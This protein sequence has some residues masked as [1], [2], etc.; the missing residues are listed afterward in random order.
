M[1]VTEVRRVLDEV[2]RGQLPAEA[3]EALARNMSPQDLVGALSYISERAG[4]AD[5]AADVTSLTRLT[6]DLLVRFARS[7]SEPWAGQIAGAAAD[8]YRA[9]LED[10]ESAEAARAVAA[11][12]SLNPVALATLYDAHGASLPEDARIRMLEVMVTLGDSAVAGRYRQKLADL[13]EDRRKRMRAEAAKAGRLEI[14]RER[15]AEGG[16]EAAVEAATLLGGHLTDNPRDHEALMLL[17]RALLAAGRPEEVEFQYMRCLADFDDGPSRAQVLCDLGRLQ[18][19]PLASPA[20]ALVS[21]QGA[22]EADRTNPDALAG[23]VTAMETSGRL[24]AAAETLERLRQDSAGQPLE[25]RIL[26]VLAGVLGRLGRL[27]EAERAWR[28]LRAIDPRNLAALRFYE[29]YHEARGDHQKLFTTLQFAISVVEDPA[30]KVRINRKMAELAE[31]RLENLE[32]AVEAYKR[33]LAADPSDARAEEALIQL[34]EKTRKWHALVEFYNERLRRLPPDAMDARVATLFRIIEIYQDPAKLPSA[35]NVLATYAR[36]AEVSPTNKEALESLARGYQTRERW[37][38]LL[39]V[40]QKKVLV[41]QD[42]VDLLELFHQIAEIAIT[43][44]SNEAQAIPFL[45]RILELDPQNLDVVQKL[46]AIYQ[47]KHNQ[48]KLYAMHLRE[49]RM[50]AGADREAVL[51][52]A[53]QMARDKLLRY[54]EALRHYEELHLLNPNLREAREN[55]HQLYTRLERWSDYAR[56][57]AEEVKRPMPAKRRIEL[58]HKLGEVLQDRLGDGAAAR[59]VFE[60]VLAEDPRDDIAARRLEQVYL[61]QDDLK[62]L[63][64]LFARRADVRS[65]VA[66]VQ[67]REAREE[68]P[69]RK[70]ALNL[71]MANACE[72]DLNEPSRATRFLEKA[73]SLDH[74]LIDVGR[75]LLEVSESQG[76]LDRAAGVLRDLAPALDDAADR[77]EAWRKQHQILSRLGR[78]ADAFAAGAEA[79]RLAIGLGDVR[80]VLD[81]LRETATSA[82]LWGEFAQVLEEVVAATLDPAWRLELLLELGSVYQGRL[83][84]HEEARGVLERVLDLD[85]GN[86]GAMDVLEDIS[87][88]REDYVGL[89]GVLRRRIDVARDPAEVREIRMRL[90]RLYEDLLGDD[91]AASEC[92]MQVVQAGSG[93]REALAGLHRTYERSERYVDLADVI[94]MEI[95]A[96]TAAPE[97]TRLR[98]ELAQVSWEHLDEYDDAVG[99]LSSVLAADASSVEAHRQ[100]RHLFERRI[101]REAAANV[102]A[103]FYRRTNRYEDLLWLLSERLEDMARPEA[104]AAILME[105][106][107]ILERAENDPGAALDRVVQAVSQHPAEAFVERLLRLADATGRHAEA[108]G[109]IGRWVGIVPDG[110]GVSTATLPDPGREAR[111][112]LLLGRLYAGKLDRP[113]LAIRAFEKALPFEEQ[114]ESLLRVLLELYRRVG[115]KESVLRTY[116]RLADAVESSGR[117]DVLMAK[118]AYAREQGLRDAAIDALK[119][120]LDS[121]EGDAEASAELESVLAESS[122]W[123][124]VLDVLE[125]RDRFSPP[126]AERAEVLYQMAVICRD[127][128]SRPE[129]A[130]DLIRRALP[131]DPGR[132]EL[133]AAAQA[134]VLDEAAATHREFA[135]PLVAALEEVLRAARETAA[136][137]P[138]LHVKVRLAGTPWDRVQALG[139]IAGLETDRGNLDAAFDAVRTAFEAMPDDPG[140]LE[141]TVDAGEAAGRIEA[142]VETLESVA[143]S[144]GVDAR[145]RI[146][147]KVAGICRARLE[148]PAR[149]MHLYDQ[150]LEVQPGSVAV[151]REIDSL[152]HEMNRE[153]ERIPLLTEMAVNAATVEEK[154]GIHLTI[155]ELCQATG[156]FDGAVRAYQYVVERRP[157]EESLDALALDGARRLLALCETL[158]R[159]RQVVDLR[160]LIGRTCAD[161]A[162]S[163]VELM[164]AAARL[165]ADL[166]EP[167]EAATV[168]DGL[169]ARDP[170]DTEARQRAKVVAREMGDLDRVLAL[171]EGEL[172]VATTSEARIAALMQVAELHVERIA[173][174]ESLR[175]AA[176][177]LAADPG[178]Q[179]AREVVGRLLGSDALAAEAA[180]TLRTAAGKTGDAATLATALAVLAERVD[181]PD[182]V[183][184]LRL[185]LGRTL[186]GL[187]RH[188]EAVDVLSAAYRERP[189]G[190]GL[191]EA[192]VEE[193]GAADRLAELD[194]VAREAAGRL[195]EKGEG[196]AARLE[197]RLRAAVALVQAGLPEGALALLDD[198][199]ADDPAHAGTLELL[200]AV[201]TN[202]G[203]WDRVVAALDLTAAATPEPEARCGA[204]LRAGETALGELRD[205]DL[206]AMYYRKVLH[207]FPLHETALPA[208]AGILESK[209]DKAG[210]VALRRAELAHL[211]NRESVTDQPRIALLRRVLVLSALEAG[212]TDAAV[213][214]ALATLSGAHPGPE[215]LAIAR[216]AYVEAGTP[217][218]LFQALVAA[219][220]RAVDRE[221]LLDLYRFVAGLDLADPA[222][223][224]AL[225][226]AVELAEALGRDDALFE[227]LLALSAIATN[228]GEVRNRLEAVGRRMGR[229]AEVHEAFVSAFAA[230]QDQP[231]A[232]DLS[233]A[234]GRL[235]RDDLGRPEDATDFLRVAFLR[236]PEDAAVRTALAELYTKLSRFGDLALLYENLGDLEA[237]E[238]ARVAWYFKAYDVVRNLV[239]DPGGATEL[240]KKVL[241]QDASNRT[242]LDELEAIA[243]E[244]SDAVSLVQVLT[245]KAELSAIQG[246]RRHALLEVAELKAAAL[247]D[248]PGAIATLQGLVEAD[249]AFAEALRKL[250]GLL[251]REQR[252]DD[253]AAQYEREA[254][255]ATGTEDRIAALKKAAAVHEGQLGDREG[256]I[257]LLERVLDLDPQ[258]T[259][260]YVRLEDLLVAG[261]DQQGVVSLLVRRLSGTVGKGEQVELHARIGRVLAEGM[262]DRAGGIEHYKA[263]LALDPYCEDARAGI[264]ALVGADDVAMEAAVALEGLYDATGQH[265]KLCDALRLE[266]KLV[267][268]PQER[269]AILLRIAEVRADRLNDAAGAL[270]TLGEALAENPSNTDTAVRLEEVA[271]RASL[272]EQLATAL[273][274]GIDAARNADVRARLHRRAA[275]VVDERL[276]LLGRA[277]QHY[278]AWLAENPGD[279]AVLARLDSLYSELKRPEEVAQVLKLRIG[280]GGDAADPALRLRLAAMLAGE[281]ADGDGAVEQLRQ[282]LAARPGNEEAIRQLSAL[283]THPVA[284]RHALEVLAA[285]FRETGDADGLLW[286][287]ERLIE[288]AADRADTAPLHEEAAS[289]ADRLNQPGLAVMHL[290]EALA[291]MPSDDAL[292]SR[293]VET[294]E[295]HGLAGEAITYLLGAAE[296]ASWPELEKTLRL[297]AARVGAVAGGSGEMVEAALKRVVEIDP[298]CR[299]GIEMLEALFSDVGRMGD[300]VE[301]LDHKLK[302]DLPHADRVST[303]QRIAKIRAMRRERDQAA[304]ALEEAAALDPAGV[305]TLRELGELYREAGDAAA[306][307]SALERL[308]TAAPEMPERVGALLA[309]ARIQSG[310]LGDA[311]AARATLEALLA[312]SPGNPAALRIL[313]GVYETLGDFE[314]LVKMLSEVVGGD[315]PGEERVAAAMRA[316]AL[317]ETNLDNLPLAIS[318]MRRAAEADPKSVP[319]A[320]DLIR[321]YYRV[322]DGPGLV[323]ALRRKAGLV[324]SRT[325]RIALLAKAC[326]V[327]LTTIQDLSLAGTISQ[328]IIKIDPTN[329]KALLTMAR[330][331][332]TRQE[333]DEALGLFRRLVVAAAEDDERVDALLGVARVLMARGERGGEVRETLESAV[334]L[335]PQH[336]EVNRHLKRLFQEAGDDKAVVEVMLREVKQAGSDADRAG[337]CMDIAE[338]HLKL[339]DGVRF[340][341]WA[342]EAYKAR[343]D[344]PRVVQGIVNFHLRSGEPKRAVP[345]LEWLVNYLEGKRRLKELP[346]YAHELG[347]LLE[348]MGQT[349]KAVQYYRL[350]HEHDAGNLVNA[351]ALGRLCM[352]R[353]EHEKALRVYQP[354]I[355]RIDSLPQS[356]R[357]E[358][359]LSLASIHAARGDKKKARQYVMRVL[360]EE[361]ENADAQALLSR[362]L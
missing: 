348:G 226:L 198:N 236:R 200:V 169:L 24:D 16:K 332:E 211:E 67:Q 150:L 41:T 162:T 333:H 317:A 215:D 185:E 118:A 361:P 359:L 104:R 228:D 37:P 353:D 299:E 251:V 318:F 186:A 126:G 129:R 77:L 92:Y 50:V 210:L 177:V 316:S 207:D 287:C 101:A 143:P 252:W 306:E 188:D 137:I 116:D 273:E 291:V 276:H 12:R 322:E 302:L 223:L 95:Q 331:M 61:D 138:V 221:G 191:F 39:K 45:E 351:L 49:L 225:R 103:P 235:L 96:A 262:S 44:M 168:L 178:H 250:E 239:K 102:L 42:P 278:S 28:R 237:A 324:A 336:P 81:A 182:E 34:Y 205:A 139:D 339:N 21:F 335:R 197:V 249:P 152:L 301:V 248:R 163:R 218:E 155:G 107:D 132:P 63:R 220:E 36:I 304:A 57:L 117:R 123:E 338:V 53:A 19:G 298:M 23:Y 131:E 140:L 344:D 125:R 88:Q 33:V 85:P 244:Q 213:S 243:R 289:V 93:D 314:P 73:W 5:Y 111:L 99:L 135:P 283:C 325:D 119:A 326:E 242:A 86:L 303:L 10:T 355:L 114:D 71:A 142:L 216:R 267:K 120:V 91:A 74:N 7:T 166:H 358:V 130:A 124:D 110:A 202:L 328:E 27:D 265:L 79:V 284:G 47:R 196:P 52:A 78:H 43:R 300:L 279:A 2:S 32:R 345:Y 72:T 26:P 14:A 241:D 89:E 187:G 256:A 175:A 151:M 238:Q 214:G 70:V 40:L 260:A 309:V 356:A 64:Q 286:A 334:R 31:G 294:A 274:A 48:E 170:S 315:G 115:Q 227:D 46:K 22:L 1:D 296:G 349:D 224:D 134:L 76:D 232:F 275:T 174:A 209:Q 180:R 38:D 165:H 35:D 293:L 297:A 288:G 184:A 277:A 11:V 13:V 90:G 240:L 84:F 179:G 97:V 80:P 217:P 108:A 60:T 156:D 172:A 4:V 350:C 157:A 330:L 271:G 17:G 147:L 56:F 167:A 313:E 269:E 340:L 69:A 272:W 183:M 190:E 337:I 68:D 266:L 323:G 59:T 281:L 261:G 25:A 128:L 75:R 6:A 20:R 285:S 87:L 189:A 145:V 212:D 354:L 347:K 357:V 270:A 342:E 327:A 54:E 127:Q 320:D 282:V 149:A 295:K 219:H 66:I 206:A 18:L 161:P 121:S 8:L 253:L 146:L 193:L 133:K 192:L 307:A 208:L 257:A 264:E 310:Q 148:D 305:E 230:H 109:A 268:T 263:A 245:R 343:R 312:F 229:L 30:E 159:V 15:L 82:S 341:Q 222:R 58:L 280:L 112:S 247:E 194:R 233:L 83:L 311:A 100:V 158:G 106:A 65:F 199:A 153:A 195:A 231:V 176:A 3:L 29:D 113:D 362:G 290:G 55:L 144:A 360:S 181:S 319:V 201:N 105:I 329:P 321:L 203:H 292:R 254:D 258:N 98:C 352:R 171:V 308:A 255:G 94:R 136:L 246:E 346:P 62:S 154:R 122:R 259:F 164:T 234:I 173:D 204:W 160:L 141:R 51:V 9:D